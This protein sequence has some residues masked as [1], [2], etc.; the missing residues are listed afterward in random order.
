MKRK[1]VLIAIAATCLA[2]VAAFGSGSAAAGTFPGT[3]GVIAFSAE[4]DTTGNSAAILAINA[5][6]SGLTP[7][8]TPPG[9]VYDSDPSYSGDGERIAFDSSTGTGTA[10]IFVMD[11]NGQNRTQLTFNSIPDGQPSFSPDGQR[12]AFS[13]AIASSSDEIFAMDANGQNEVQ[14]TNDAFGDDQ[15]SFSPDGQRIVFRRVIGF[16]GDIFVMNA[17]GSNQVPLTTSPAEDGDPAWSPDGTRI[18]FSSDAGGDSE[19]VVMDA[20]G[21][22]PQPLTN[23]SVDDYAPVF[24]PDGQ[25][26]A[27]TQVAPGQDD[28]IIVMDAN[29]QNQTPLTNNNVVDYGPDW[30]PLNPPACDVSGKPKQKSAKQV[31]VTISCTEDAS[32][33]AS[34]ELKAPKAPELGAAGSKSKQVELQPVTQEIPAN[35]PTPVTLSP[36]KKGKKLLK[37]ALKAGKKPKGSVEIAAVDDLG[38]SAQDSFAVTLKP[39]RK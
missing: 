11:H 15:P 25:K 35:T 28:E 19:I 38:Q 6:G 23:N 21:Q 17:D 14:L 36:S 29:G 2:G 16:V 34:G 37:K 10:E 18:I 31:R 39:K 3:N 26:I 32:V 9:S 1:R 13:R 12:I 30:Q 20:N 4:Q 27:F 33:T 24:S 8:T 7:L 22:N 5:D